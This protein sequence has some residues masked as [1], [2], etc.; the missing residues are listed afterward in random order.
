MID[1]FKKSCYGV[2]AS[3]THILKLEQYR[4]DEHG[5]CARMTRK[6]VKWSIFKKKTKKVTIE[7]GYVVMEAEE[8]HINRLQ[9][10]KPGKLT[11]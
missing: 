8:S 11:P 4:E 6:F 7:I 1:F 10:G 5:P 2:L 3:A 9:A